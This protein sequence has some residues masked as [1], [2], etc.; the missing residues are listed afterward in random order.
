MLLNN[1]LGDQSCLP[2]LPAS[3]YIDALTK[4]ILG[5][6]SSGRCLRNSDGGCSKQGPYDAELRFWGNDWP[7]HGY[8][9][10][11]MARLLNLRAA[12]E[13]IN[14]DLIPGSIIEMGVWR[15]GGM[16][17]AAALCKEAGFVRNIYLFDAFDTILE[18]DPK[19]A[20]FLTTTADSVL[21][22]FQEFDLSENIFLKVGMFYDTVMTWNASE[23]IAIL[24]VDGNFYDSYQDAM[25]YCYESVSIGGIV[26]FDDVMSHRPVLK[27]WNDFLADQKLNITLN[28]IDG[29]S[30][31]FRKTEHVELDWQ[32]YRAPR[33]ANKR[34]H[35]HHPSSACPDH[36]MQR[37][38]GSCHSSWK[39]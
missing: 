10:V 17:L 35:I 19:I 23:P 37:A 22:N 7:P 27:F 34:A 12:V 26:I 25:Y 15:G 29:H 36:I 3:P 5:A 8:T 21:R 30:A 18:Y 9:M 31:W 16:M 28:V 13:N 20:S 39:T 14:R 6:P 33:D 32:H 24:R 1:S 38:Q 4:L 11:G 2:I